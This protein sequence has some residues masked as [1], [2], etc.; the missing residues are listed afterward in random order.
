MGP[1]GTRFWDPQGD[2]LTAH[3]FDSPVTFFL[4]KGWLAEG[5]PVMVKGLAGPGAPHV[6]QFDRRENLSAVVGFNLQ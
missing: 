1:A 2:V 5:V 6:L 3:R 4:R